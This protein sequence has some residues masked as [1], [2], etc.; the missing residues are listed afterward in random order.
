M[1]YKIVYEFYSDTC[2]TRR[3]NVFMF[4]IIILEYA[5]IYTNFI[6]IFKFV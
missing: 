2:E 3:P 5:K 6:N 1:L 4:L